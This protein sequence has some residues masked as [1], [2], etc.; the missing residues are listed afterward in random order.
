MDVNKYLKAFKYGNH[1]LIRIWSK[2]KILDT[3]NA[4]IYAIIFINWI[5]GNLT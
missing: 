4:I 3:Q 5:L 1:V 2:F